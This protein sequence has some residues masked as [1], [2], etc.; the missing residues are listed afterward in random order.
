MFFYCRRRR[1]SSSSPTTTP[2]PSAS[3]ASRSRTPYVKDAFHRRVVERRRERASNPDAARH[4]GGRVA[5]LR[6]AR[7]RIGR[8]SSCASRPRARARSVRRQRR[9]PRDAPRARPT[10]T[11]PPSR[12]RTSPTIAAPSIA[13][14]RRACSGRS[15]SINFDVDAWLNGDVVK[16][17]PARAPRAQL[18]LAPRRRGRRHLHARHL[19]VPLVRRLGSRL[20]RR[21]HGLDRHRLR[22]R[23]SSS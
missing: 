19:G 4:Q 5:A 22:P 3:S 1:R 18:G 9:A 6:R 16:P 10:R 13:R 20:P 14:P 21:R 12:A 23:P 15:S 17:P 2:T 11:T 7:R 8:A